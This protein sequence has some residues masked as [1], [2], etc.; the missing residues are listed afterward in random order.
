MKNW[1]VL[2]IRKLALLIIMYSVC[3]RLLIIWEV[4]NSMVGNLFGVHH[5]H[6]A[7]YEIPG[8]PFEKYFHIQPASL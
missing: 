3:S 1:Y 8:R 6:V 7:E 5:I 2:R 4:I